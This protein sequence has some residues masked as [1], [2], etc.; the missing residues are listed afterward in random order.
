MEIYYI[1]LNNGRYYTG[2]SFEKSYNITLTSVANRTNAP[3]F[4]DK[5]LVHDFI[6]LMNHEYLNT[7]L[8]LETVIITNQ[9][10]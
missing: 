4:V 9:R 7:E 6:T 8:S 5:K 2:L 10:R 3:M 1:K